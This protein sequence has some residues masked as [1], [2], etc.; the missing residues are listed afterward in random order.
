MKPADVSCLKD[1]IRVH[2]LLEN[3]WISRE[4]VAYLLRI[5]Q[6]EV[7]QIIVLLRRA[8]IIVQTRQ[9]AKLPFDHQL[10]TKALVPRKI[11]Q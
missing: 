2:R 10:R 8:G 11:L 4:D 1:A 9:Q 5:R 7:F 3:R 6:S